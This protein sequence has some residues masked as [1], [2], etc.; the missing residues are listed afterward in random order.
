MKD[1]TKICIL[2]KQ[3]YKSQLD[4]VQRTSVECSTINGTFLLHPFL[5]SVELFTVYGFEGKESSFSVRL[6]LLIGGL[7]STG[8][9]Q[10]RE[11][12]N[13]TNWN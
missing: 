7:Y 9:S 6:W 1:I 11:Y 4:N 5:L 13:H 3:Y 8:W 10:T 12:V 2:N